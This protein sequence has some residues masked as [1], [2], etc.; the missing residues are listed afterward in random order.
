M[1]LS[2]HSFLTKS[3]TNRRLKADALSRRPD[4]DGGEHEVQAVRR[5]QADEAMR[6]LGLTTMDATDASVAAT[7]LI[8]AIKAAY[9]GDAGMTKIMKDPKRYH[10]RIQD[11]LLID[12]LDRIIVPA[13]RVLRTLIIR[14]NHDIDVSGHLGISKTVM[15]IRKHFDW[16][17]M[18]NDVYEFVSSCTECQKSKSSIVQPAGLMNPI[19]PPMTKGA[20]ISIDFV[21]P[22]PR[23]ARG[24][25]FI[26]VIVD[27]FS[28]RVWYEPC[29]STVTG[30]QAARIIF[31]RVVRHQGLPEIIVSDRDPRFN[32][33]IWRELWRECGTTLAMTV[34]FKAEANGL[35][36]N[37]NRTM[38]D[39]LRSFVNESR[40]DWD[41]KLAALEV[42]YNSSHNA[43]T[44]FSPFELDI[45]MQPRLPIDLS[46]KRHR[47]QQSVAQ[48]LDNWES[49]W[50]LA[51]RHIDRAQQKQKR[52]ADM[53]RRSEQYVIGDRAWLRHDRGTL[54]DGISMI[55]KLGPR[56]E[57]PYEVIELHTVITT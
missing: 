29:R 23:T 39:M 56:V 11:G 14:E 57:G 27:R 5:E 9:K 16:Y 8:S 30:K 15:R 33:K 31:D 13:H 20:S 41:T 2:A 55:D 50:A 26:M 3:A 54:G 43:T 7:D 53:G 49:N 17:G 46:I 42:A 10:A 25:N 28:K 18:V 34:S 37:N 1:D 52:Y 44:G 48:F 47:S 24:K 19:P 36:E 4:L 12:K 35:A 6:H 40:K 51:H 38:Q 22:L 45:G 21:G 32:S